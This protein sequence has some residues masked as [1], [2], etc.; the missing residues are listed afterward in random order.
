MRFWRHFLSTYC[1]FLL[2]AGVW[3]QAPLQDLSSFVE[4][5]PVAFDAVFEPGEF[6]VGGALGSA[7]HSSAGG[8]PGEGLAYSEGFGGV[9]PVFV[10]GGEP[11]VRVAADEPLGDT[12]LVKVDGPLGVPALDGQL[13]LFVT[14]HGSLEVAKR[15]LFRPYLRPFFLIEPV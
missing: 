2:F 13:G 3:V 11:L 14:L 8:E 15:V 7:G 10:D 1:G 4:R 5:A 6:A 9:V 12:D